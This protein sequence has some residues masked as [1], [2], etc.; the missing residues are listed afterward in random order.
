MLKWLT[1]F[2]L[3]IAPPIAATVIGAFL[4]HQLWPSGKSD[5]PPVATPPAQVSTDSAKPASTPRVISTKGTDATAP[6]EEAPVTATVSPP[7]SGKSARQSNDVAKTVSNP[8]LPAPRENV[9]ERA[10]KALAAIPPAKS[11]TSSS[12]PATQPGATSRATAVVPLPP[13]PPQ[14]PP[15]DTAVVAPV[16]APPPT[17]TAAVTPM[18]PPP[19]DPPREIGSAVS[20]GPPPGPP[21]QVVHRERNPLRVYNNDRANLADI[22][23][24]DGDEAAPQETA[25]APQ[26]SEQAPQSPP[27]EKNIVENILGSLHSVLPERLR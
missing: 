18:A 11:G 13:T 3:E 19:M 24:A 25:A 2:T 7:G 17:S 12:A 22:P 6:K 27:R 15:T 10:E 16:T 9:F 4:V 5:V 20:I 8:P 14:A 23:L 21:P 26:P 1:R